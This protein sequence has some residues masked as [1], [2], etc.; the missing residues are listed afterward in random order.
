MQIFFDVHL[1]YYIFSQSVIYLTYLQRG[2]HK[3]AP[4]SFMF[5][6]KNYTECTHAG[7]DGIGM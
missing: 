6:D 3:S 2:V 5:D 4:V 7:S 1:S